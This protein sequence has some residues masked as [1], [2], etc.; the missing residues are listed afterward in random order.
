MK[1]PAYRQYLAE[2]DNWFHT[3][4]RTLVRNCLARFVHAAPERC[5]V[6]EVGAGD[7]RNVGALA[8]LGR[9]DV[10]EFEPAAVAALKARGAVRNIYQS[11]VPFAL[12]RA[13]DVICAMDVIEH[14][15]DDQRVFAWLADH[16]K[17]HGVL[18]L[19]VP[20]YQL[21]FGPH[22]EAL[23]HYRRYTVGR[24]LAL[25]RG[26]LRCVKK[27]YFNALLFPL[28]ATTRLWGRL[29][30]R[31]RQAVRKQSSSVPRLFDRLFATVLDVE[32][33]LIRRWELFPFGLTA[34]A[35]FTRV[36]AE[37]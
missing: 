15:R 29:V 18:F 33:R 13:Y 16:L 3:G 7:G 35:V 37:E 27:G 21:L 11:E 6:L 32:N 34:F 17:P 12:E 2:A 30:P 20:A 9:V 31:R 19:T 10:I 8:E 23:G 28:A 14:T 1:D 4:R 5:E 25:N 22:D 24:L 36:G 26:S